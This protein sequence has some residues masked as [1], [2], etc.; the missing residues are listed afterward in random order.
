[1]KN[2]SIN[3]L[4]KNRQPIGAQNIAFSY[5]ESDNHIVN[6]KTKSGDT[7]MTINA[8]EGELVLN[9]ETGIFNELS[10]DSPVAKIKV[11]NIKLDYNE[12]LTF[13]VDG[14]KTTYR[15]SGKTLEQKIGRNFENVISFDDILDVDLPS[16]LFSDIESGLVSADGLPFQMFDAFT[17]EDAQR[18]G[19]TKYQSN[20][21]L[22]N[23]LKVNN[24]LYIGR[25]HRLIEIDPENM[26]FYA[27]ENNCVL[28]ITVGR[29][30][31]ITGKQKSGI[32]FNLTP[33][34]LKD[35]ALFALGSAEN[36]QYKTLE[37][38]QNN[39]IDYSRVYRQSATSKT[40]AEENE[41][42]NSVIPTAA[43]EAPT[44]QPEVE[45]ENSAAPT[46]ENIA[47][48]QE[49]PKTSDEEPD[50]NGQPEA[51][52]AAEQDQVNT[53]ANLAEQPAVAQE[54]AP[55]KKDEKPKEDKK[56]E[57][58]EDKPKEESAKKHAI[59]FSAILTALSLIAFFVTA[60]PFF[61]VMAAAC[62]GMEFGSLVWYTSESSK[63]QVKNKKK[64]KAK[65]KQIKNEKSKENE[66][67]A[68]N[69]N[70]NTLNKDEEKQ[71]EP[72]TRELS[73]VNDN[74]LHDQAT[75]SSIMD[76]ENTAVVQADPTAVTDA[77]ENK[78]NELRNENIFKAKATRDK[79]ARLED[80][81][82]MT[83]ND[84]S[85]SPA[86][87]EKIAKEQKRLKQAWE[88]QK[89]TLIT[90]IN[91]INNEQPKTPTQSLQQ[92]EKA[93]DFLKETNKCLDEL[94]KKISDLFN[95]SSKK[96]T[97]SNESND[98]L[99]R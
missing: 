76:E 85:L 18:L 84:D 73:N 47:E 45:N 69:I 25:G 34:E 74:K 28:G 27:S 92:Q 2:F 37:D 86:E 55:E 58:K 43:Q 91:N 38:L 31:G 12:N 67:T 5:N 81:L 13:T 71:A 97:K 10:T 32:A 94:F 22:L 96:N 16:T 83:F 15:I 17:E 14:N 89:Q 7:L 88:Q 44:I 50:G 48:N 78:C 49:A 66:N 40:I 90:T 60:F 53:Q 95:F 36:V 46:D 79:I 57:K 61:L 23:M 24:K 19:I 42:Q 80:E 52:P 98:S 75:Y 39:D 29:S 93:R 62:S 77:T 26:N 51:A 64:K 9:N 8:E 33:N 68:E 6:F 70:E 54:K 63:I 99:D 87:L 59:Y 82:D 1:M 21:K 72:Q 20:S 3:C 4:G 11:S 65:D 30:S 41:A 35:V 56:D